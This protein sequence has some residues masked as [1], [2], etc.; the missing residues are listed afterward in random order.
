[1][2][3]IIAIRLEEER[4]RL[5]KKKGEMADSGGVVGSAYTNY[6]EGKRAPDAE[7]LAAIAAAGADVQYILIGVRSITLAVKPATSA[8]KMYALKAATETVENA[9]SAYT[10]G[11]KPAIVQILYGLV[12]G[13]IDQIDEAIDIIKGQ[14]VIDF[15]KA[16]YAFSTQIQGQKMAAE[17][18]PGYSGLSQEQKILLEDFSQCAPEDQQAIL[19]MAQLAAKA[20]NAGE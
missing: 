13:E 15:N 1:M 14:H 12:T 7:F 16:S 18:N 2:R 11:I 6:L 5:E 9:C 8:Q 19:R 20:K 10:T 4:E 3:K 17:E